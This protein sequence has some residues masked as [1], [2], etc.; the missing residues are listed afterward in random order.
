VGRVSAG[1]AG[2]NGFEE[3]LLDAVGMIYEAALEPGLWPEALSR[4]AG[5][6]GA[7]WAPCIVA[8]DP[9]VPAMFQNSLA[10]PEQLTRMRCFHTPDTNPF[11]PVMLASPLGRINLHEEW[12]TD[13]QWKRTDI[14]DEL[15]RPIDAVAT[16]AV[17][18][19]RS[20]HCFASFGAVRARS[21]GGFERND[22]SA[23]SRL[24][25]HLQRAV[26]LMLRLDRLGTQAAAMQEAWNRLSFGIMALDAKGRLLW[27]NHAG[28]RILM[29]NDGLS[30]CGG[31]LHARPLDV[32]GELQRLIGEAGLTTNGHGLQSGGATVIPRNPPA[33]PL[34]LIVSPIRTADRGLSFRNPGTPAVLV[35]VN[36]PDQIPDPPRALLR[37]LYRLTERE[38]ALAALLLEGCD[39]REAGEKMGVGIGTVRTH[40]RQL[41]EKTGTRRQAE[42]V[43]LLLRSTVTVEGG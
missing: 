38:A 12:F 26:S 28:E 14:Y 25:P 22:L 29:Q 30:A 20:S 3:D 41:F 17:P 8:P 6:C 31:R 24:I 4:V 33:R 5:V 21:R 27:T 18:L 23:L 43:R 35:L 9:I 19:L 32:N 16:L 13:R 2:T 7:K 1:K 42:L 39:L 36:D 34:A 37:Q 11:I 40:L 10:D 15:V